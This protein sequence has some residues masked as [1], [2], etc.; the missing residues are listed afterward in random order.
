MY[1]KN[2]SLLLQEIVLPILTYFL[3]L[4]NFFQIWVPKNTPIFIIFFTRTNII[5][6]HVHTNFYDSEMSISCVLVVKKVENSI[7]W[8]FLMPSFVMND[9][10]ELCIGSFV[11]EDRCIIF[12]GELTE[13]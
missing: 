5:P 4:G 2:F 12:R 6:L 9:A 13:L 3:L 1:I 8:Q 10:T 11:D 7:L